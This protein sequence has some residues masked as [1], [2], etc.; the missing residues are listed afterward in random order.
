M[1]K[2]RRNLIVLIAVILVTA[3][4]TVLAFTGINGTGIYKLVP[5][6]KEI[7]GGTDFAGGRTAVYQIKEEADRNRENQTKAI[8]AIDKRLDTLKA[9]E[10]FGHP[11]I[12]GLRVYAQGEDKVRIETPEYYRGGA[13]LGVAVRGQ[14]ISETLELLTYRGY[15]TL[16][17]AEGNV[18]LNS[19]DFTGAHTELIRQESYYQFASINV[20]LTEEGQKKLID[21]TANATDQ[22]PEPVLDEEGNSTQQEPGLKFNFKMDGSQMMEVVYTAPFTGTELIVSPEGVDM[23]GAVR[24]A[25]LVN[26]GPM[27]AELQQL[28]NASITPTQGFGILNKLLFGSLIGLAVVMVLILILYRSGGIAADLALLVFGFLLM[29]GL[30]TIQSVVITPAA[31]L[32]MT[33]AM[34]V[35]VMFQ[36]LL[37]ESVS[38]SIQMGAAVLAAT[39]KC[40]KNTFKTV[41]DVLIMVCLGG[42]MCYFLGGEMLKDFAIVAMVGV[43]FAFVAYFVGM[44]LLVLMGGLDDNTSHYRRM[45]STAAAN[46][47]K[48]QAAEQNN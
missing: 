44:G 25:R 4:L 8:T 3:V 15:F 48:K 45:G 5:M 29:L 10:D 16:E 30:S 17:D 31:L 32:G 36:V 2:R 28:T 40:L 26:D 27:P 41:L 1:T 38:R 24:T 35:A 22:E 11:H 12:E 42:A 20:E 23:A 19:D 7:K 39:E 13:Q 21:A 33:A 34:L 37:L 6:Y 47:D 43:V 9:L 14:V 46:Q 18:V